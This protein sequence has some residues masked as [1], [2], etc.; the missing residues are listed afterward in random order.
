MENKINQIIS[1]FIL[2]LT[3]NYIVEKIITNS[4]ITQN[5]QTIEAFSCVYIRFITK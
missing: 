4:K 1:I 3:A 5:G 2:D